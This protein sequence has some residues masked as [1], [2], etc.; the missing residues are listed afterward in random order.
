MATVAAH[1]HDAVGLI[2]SARDFCDVGFARGKLRPRLQGCD[3]GD[4]TFCLRGNDILWK[5]QVGTATAG[6]GSRNCLMNDA[7]RLRR[8]GDCFGVERDVTEQ[9][10]GL[11]RLDVVSPME[12]AWHVAGQCQR[13]WSRLASWRPA[14]RW[15]LPGPVVPAHT[16]S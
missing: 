3:T 16:D 8:G 11:C 6:I 9:Q 5:R 4:T 13:A 10:I 2:D 15:L 14:T 7:R 1:D 12:L